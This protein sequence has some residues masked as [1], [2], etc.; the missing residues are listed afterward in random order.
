[1]KK[2]NFL[3][4]MALAVVMVFG[5]ATANAQIR[6]L[7]Q[8]IKEAATEGANNVASKTFAEKLSIEKIPATFEEF[9]ALQAEMGTTPEG[10][11]M[12]QLVAMEMYRRDKNL[13]QQCL[14]LN[15]TETN[16]SS[17]TRRLNE[18]F[19]ENDSYARP[20]IVSAMFKGATP[21][22]GYTPDKPY[23]IRLR[24][25]PTKT[26]Q[27][28]QILKGV[29]KYIQ[30]YSDGYDTPWRNVDV[31]Q[32]KGDTYYRVSNCPAIVTQCKE[33]DFDAT[34]DWTPME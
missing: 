25:D 15:N 1:M 23:T 17:V 6:G 9:Q 14:A 11:V 18:L 32:Q 10:C 31:V 5:A 12:L 19:R 16:L 8:K 13:G 29:V 3:T 27:R 20:Y 26:D 33:V 4:A 34:Q 30:V 7:G 2:Q 21:A 24:K 22:N 28:S